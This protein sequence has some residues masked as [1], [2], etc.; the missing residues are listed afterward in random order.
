LVSH[1]D[2]V[3]KRRGMVSHRDLVIKRDLQQQ[4][5]KLRVRLHKLAHTTNKQ[6]VM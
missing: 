4:Y 2:L 3:I 6:T 5:T 1:G